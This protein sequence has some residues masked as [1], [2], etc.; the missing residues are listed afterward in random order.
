[1][2]T[3]PFTLTAEGASSRAAAGSGNPGL[4]PR[5]CPREAGS[6]RSGRSPYYEAEGVII[7]H[8]DC[9]EI[10][11]EISGDV[12]I[13]DP[14]YGV[15]I[16]Y[17][18]SQAVDSLAHAKQLYEDFIALALGS[19][20]MLLTTIGCFAIEKHLYAV[21]PPAWRL[22]WRK[23][24]TSRPSPV[25]FT[26]WEPVFVYGEKVHRNAHDLFTVQP[27]KM[28]RFGHPCPK[29]L[30]FAEWLISRFVRDGETLI[31]PFAGSGTML[32][33][34]KD[35]NLKCIGIEI[36]ERFC[37]IAAR[38]LSQSVLSL[39]GGGAE[40][41]GDETATQHSGA[42]SQNDPS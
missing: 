33:A 11:P 7:Y 39:G 20:P 21:R 28:G 6:G 29:P 37:E 27:E 31:D 35:R 24:I 34:A 5:V 13:T 42:G 8:G 25:G 15:G 22:C 32:R 12:V 3:V 10:L 16:E 1:M 38:R 17:G 36:E 23:G 18:D 4:E 26:D 9:R 40:Q 30:G 14:P 2:Q 41:V 19:A